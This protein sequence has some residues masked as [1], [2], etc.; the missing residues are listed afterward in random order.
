[1]MVNNGD[2]QKVG[3]NAPPSDSAST[4]LPMLAGGLVLII[5]SPIVVVNIRLRVLQKQSKR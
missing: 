1:M 2:E 3:D 5:I 4:L